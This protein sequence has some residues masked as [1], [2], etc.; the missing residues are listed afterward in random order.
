MRLLE[1]LTLATLVFLYSQFSLAQVAPPEG[2]IPTGVNPGDEFYII[3]AGSDTLNGAQT[4]ATYVNYAASVKQNDPDTD[5]VTGW[6]TLF[7]HDDASLVT[8]S[9]F[10]ANT[11][12]PIYNTNGDLVAPNAAAFFSSSQTSAI[13]FDEGGNSYSGNVWTGF[14][15]TG[16]N[17][18]IGDDSL[19]GNDS[20]TDGCLAGTSTATDQQWAASVL[21]GGNGCAGANLPLYVLSPLFAVPSSPQ[22]VPTLPI[23]AFLISMLGLGFAAR[24]HITSR[25]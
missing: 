12:Q 2:L 20:L 21:A 15:F 25:Q 16:S 6:T 9:A 1:R 23:W 17:T 7:G 14:N 22:S 3:F 19:G 24:S 10:G 8:L 4:S 13:G 11:S 18:G 5:A